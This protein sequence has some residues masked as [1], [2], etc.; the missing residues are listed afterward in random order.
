MSSLIAFF[1]SEKFLYPVYN[2]QNGKHHPSDI[3]RS[4]RTTIGKKCILV[5]HISLAVRCIVGNKSVMNCTRCPMY[6]WKST[7]DC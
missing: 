6:N 1:L 7:T 4:V 5:D 3:S 2:A